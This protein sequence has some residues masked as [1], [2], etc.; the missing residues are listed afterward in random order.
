[1]SP[2]INTLT[3]SL[4]ILLSHRFR[5]TSKSCMRIMFLDNHASLKPL[6][7]SKKKPDGDFWVLEALL[8]GVNAKLGDCRSGT[9]PWVS[10]MTA[11]L[12]HSK[13]MSGLRKFSQLVKPDLPIPEPSPNT[14]C[15]FSRQASAGSGTFTARPRDSDGI[16]P[17]TCLRCGF[18]G[19]TLQQSTGLRFCAT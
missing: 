19:L 14:G 13:R 7:A 8:M 2:G 17:G 1:M 11:A 4:A 15:R 10:G 18:P 16:A 3:S 12:G 9:W 5:N 6:N